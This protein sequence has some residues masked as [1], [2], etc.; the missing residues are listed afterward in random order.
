[1]AAAA[2]LGVLFDNFCC[3]T[4]SVPAEE[5]P[6]IVIGVSNVQSGPSS[7]LG[8]TLLLGSKAYFDL[9]NQHGGIRGR[10]IAIILKDDK[11]EPDPAIQNTNELIE[12]DKVFFLFDYVGTPTLTRVLPL[13]KYY[14]KEDIVNVAPFTGADPQR[15]PPYDRFVFN[16]RAS[17]REETRALVGYLYRQGYRRIGFLGQADAYG[18]SGEIGVNAALREYGLK[19]VS[20]VTYPRNQGLETPMTSQV[21]L[22]RAA[23]AEAVIAVGVYGPCAAFVRDARRSGWNIPIANVSFAGPIVMLQK[24][25]QLS[26][27]LSVDL[28]ANL[29]NSQVVPSTDDIRYPLVVDY[30]AHNPLQLDSGVAL[31]GWLNAVVVTEALRRGGPNP[32]R[33]DFIHAMESLHDFDPGLGIKLEFSSTNHQGLHKIWLNQTAHGRWQPVPAQ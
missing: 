21:E 25:S 33:R 13:L 3:T 26:Q 8:Q 6:P 12:Q 32:S 23:G 29:I 2:F 27:Q 16:I 10:K 31:E 11:Y 14:Q 5:L 17:Y 20:S 9:V 22:L 30:R 7:M 24:L 28:T 18:K 4:P 1:L 15:T 19:I